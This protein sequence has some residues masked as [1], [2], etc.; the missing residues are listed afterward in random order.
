MFRNKRAHMLILKHDLRLEVLMISW[1]DKE[2][3]FCSL[4]FSRSVDDILER[5]QNWF[6]NYSI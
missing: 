6:M 3:A 5:T 4:L 1:R 2:F